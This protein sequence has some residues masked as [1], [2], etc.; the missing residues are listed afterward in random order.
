MKKME[1]VY[2]GDCATYKGIFL[3]SLY[4]FAMVIVGVVL[5]FALANSFLTSS[6]VLF[7]AYGISIVLMLVCGIVAGIAP[8]T[9]PVTGTLSALAMGYAVSFTGVLMPEYSNIYYLAMV[10][11]LAIVLAMMFV[12][13]SGIVKV[14]DNF[15]KVLYTVLL[16]SIIGSL[17]LVV[18]SFI[19]ATR[20]ATML[21]LTNPVVAILISAVDI[22]LASLFLLIDFNDIERTVEARL[23]KAY[24]WVASFSLV[25]TVV[26]LYLE[27][28]DLLLKIK[29]MVD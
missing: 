13:F 8:K 26:W 19:P 6:T 14:T 28:L 12:Y 22:I 9:T 29:D 20:I 24:E 25:I 7:A 4:F 11:T 16:A 17:L 18:C 10:L 3:K 5:A 27:I 23:P 21:F 15:R 1:G 2:E